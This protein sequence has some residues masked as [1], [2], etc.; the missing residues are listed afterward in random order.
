MSQLAYQFSKYWK[1]W[2]KPTLQDFVLLML[3]VCILGT[4]LLQGLLWFAEKTIEQTT[5]QWTLALKTIE[6]RDTKVNEIR[7]C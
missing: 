1:M 6:L 2:Y 3:E 5:K 4:Q 7:G